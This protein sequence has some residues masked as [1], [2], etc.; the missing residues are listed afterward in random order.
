M[1]I[2]FIGD[3]VGSAGRKAIR[4][5]LPWLR[6]KYNPTFIIINGE[7]AA[8][9]KG[10]TAAIANELFDYGAHAITLGNHAW[11]N[12]EIFEWIDNEPRIVR[13]ANF[14]QGTPGNGY[15]VVKSGN[16]ELA[17]INAQGR[18]FL[19][20]LDCP[21]RKLDEILE[22]ELK[23]RHVFVDFHAEAT[24]EKIAMGWYLDGRVTAIVGTHTHVQ[25]HDERILP[26]G[27]AYITD[28][29]MTGSREGVLGM[30]RSAVIQKFLTGLPVRFVA[31]EGK[32]QLHGVLIETNDQT[33]TAS[34]IRLIRHD[35][36]EFVME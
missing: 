15:T 22:D 2:L 26:N 21:F 18:T 5:K 9:G 7:N 23:T 30:E 29:G 19:P 10:I 4:T 11:D 36:D 32:W 16:H 35:E 13:P 20:P 25:T 14:P 6:A 17:I 3:V 28:V 24:S 1:K 8:G 33:G 34:S 27:T 31:D 12:K